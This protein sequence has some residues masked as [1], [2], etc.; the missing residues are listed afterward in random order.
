MPFVA[1]I[2]KVNQQLALNVPTHVVFET[3]MVS[4]QLRS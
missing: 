1:I 3:A 2:V 4:E